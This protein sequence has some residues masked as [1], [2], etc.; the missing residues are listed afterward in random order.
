M[1]CG[2]VLQTFTLP[3]E[4]QGCYLLSTRVEPGMSVYERGGVYWYDF[5]FQRFVENM[6]PL[7]LRVCSYV[8]A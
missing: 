4:L 2:T 3:G 8:A 7:G 6:N 5:W 1:P